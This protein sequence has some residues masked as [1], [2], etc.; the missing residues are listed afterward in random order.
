MKVFDAS[1]VLTFLL[2]EEN[3]LKAR[4]VL[5]EGGVVPEW[6]FVEVANTLATKTN[7]SK[8]EAERAFDLVCE[9][10]L[11]QKRIDWFLLKRS[12]AEA[13]K[14]GVTVYDMI[15]AQ[16]AFDL[17]TELITADLKFVERTGYSWVRSL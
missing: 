12:M 5:S 2:E 16:L 7:F 1:V 6:L 15:Y 3:R 10:K 14:L 13:K 8:R 17:K 11:E 9:L 4:I